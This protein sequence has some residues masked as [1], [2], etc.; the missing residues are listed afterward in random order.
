MATRTLADRSERRHKKLEGDPGNLRDDALQMVRSLRREARLGRWPDPRWQKDPEGFARII[1]GVEL[2]E[3][4]IAI[5]HSIVA[6][7]HTAIMGGRK[8]GKD[9]VVAV[10]ALWWYASF[11]DARVFMLAVTEEQIDDVFYRQVKILHHQSGR[12][13]ACKRADAFG[14]TPCEHSTHLDGKAHEKAETGVKTMK[15][16]DLREITGLTARAAEGAQGISGTRVLY[17]QDEASGQ[18]D[19][20]NRSILGNMASSQCRRVILSNGT[21]TEGFFFDAF[22]EPPDRHVHSTF[23]VSSLESPNVIAGREIYPGLAD[24]LWIEEMKRLWGEDSVEYLVHVLGKFAEGEEKKAITLQLIQESV[25]RWAATTFELSDRI[26]IGLDVAGE[27]EK[28]DESIF[29]VRR[30]PKMLSLLAFRGLTIDDHLAHVTGIVRGL[31]R[32]NEG[33]PLVVIDASGPI[34]Y[35]VNVVISAFAEKHP[36]MFQ[37]VG[38]RADSIAQD[39]MNYDKRRDELWASTVAW[40]RAGGALLDDPKLAAELHCPEWSYNKWGQR[41]VTPKLLMKKKLKRS[42]DRADALNLALWEPVEWE[43]AGSEGATSHDRSQAM[44]PPPEGTTTGI[45]PYSLEALGS[46]GAQF[47]GDPIYGGGGN[48]GEPER[49]RNR[50]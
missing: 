37:S 2:W 43:L 32:R 35:R 45:D 9:F 47:G 12:C 15:T 42:P 19:A 6:N 3:K 48:L 31:R 29:V 1:L 39:K 49:S 30:G 13:L 7:R 18:S 33:L 24:R 10:A 5:L 21:R 28:G 11:E 25:K 17:V 38:V 34:G 23:Q 20:N 36:E 26:Q 44:K 46:T 8:I 22:H 27:G 50:R 4:Q 14:P 40:L 16:G 41:F